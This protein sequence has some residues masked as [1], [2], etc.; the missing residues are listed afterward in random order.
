MTRILTRNLLA[1]LLLPAL[2]AGAGAKAQQCFVGQGPN[3]TVQ[4]SSTIPSTAN[5]VLVTGPTSYPSI[6]QT[7]P[8]VTLTSPNVSGNMTVPNGGLLLGAATGGF[9]GSGSLN[10]Q[11]IFINGS[12]IGSGG[13][14]IPNSAL[15]S[16]NGS[17]LGSVAI[18]TNLTLSGSY[19]TQT[20]NATG[21]GGGVTSITFSS[22]LT[23]GTITTS[24]TVG[25]G[26]IPVTNLN[27][28]T[29]ASGT[30]FWAGDGTWKTPA[31]GGS[32]SI[33]GGDASIV[34]SPS[35][36]V[37]TGTVTV[38]GPSHLT[39]FTAGTLPMGA[40]ASAF[41]ASE[42][43]DV[44]SVGVVIGAPTGGAKGAG[45]INVQTCF[46][47]NVPCA[48]SGGGG[49]T[50]PSTSDIVI[51]NGTSSPAGLA[52]VNNDLVYATAGAWAALASAN[53]SV[54]ITSAG[55]VPSLSTTL[56]SGI[57]ATSM[58]LTTPNIG[59][60]TGTSLSV[61]GQLTSTVSTGT[62][63]LVV[64]STTNVPNLN[65][66]SLGGATFAAPGP[67]GGGTPSTGAFAGLTVTS[68]LTATG[69]V[70]LAD[71]ATQATNTV[72]GNATSGTA[73][74]TALAVGSCSTAASAVIWTTNVGFGCNTSITA[75]T[76]PATGLTGT[77]NAAQ[78]PAFTGNVTSPA[79]SSVNTIPAN[80]VTNA[81]AAQMAL[82]TIKGN[83]TAG[84]ANATD[85]A[86][87]SCPD[88]SGN[89][90]NWVNGTGITCGTTSSGGG[91]ST[92]FT[93]TVTSSSGTVYTMTAAGYAAT[94]GNIVCTP[95]FTPANG[96]NPTLNIAGTGAKNIKFLTATGLV[97]PVNSEIPNTGPVCFM[98]DGTNEVLQTALVSPVPLT[99]TDTVTAPKWAGC[100]SYIISSAAQTITLPASTG[101]PTG[102]CITVQTIGVTAQLTPTSGDA[103]DNG[104]L[105]GGAAN[106][107]ITIPADLTT[108]VSYS[109]TPGVT[110]FLVP[111]GPA[112][113]FPMTWGVGQ[114]LSLDTGGI[115]FGRFATPRVVYG[116]KCKNATA[117]GGGQAMTFKY[118]TDAQTIAG[119]TTIG[120]ST[121]DMTAAA[122]TE[123]TI[124]LT[125][126]PLLVPAAYSLGGT[127]SGSSTTGS[128][129]C[130]F[131]YR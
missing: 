81:M 23:G 34:V 54:L 86:V 104:L 46:I 8:S 113:Y 43:T 28:G 60:A 82:Y 29:G 13:V 66:S 47:N 38:G 41:V 32:V 128:G 71:H 68:S 112:Q 72:I 111:L 33:T 107:S 6:S 110:A 18:G 69:L 55:G 121:F 65:A 102:G 88:T 12:P 87:P 5:G 118:A 99:G 51:S 105:G 50:W 93:G 52:P 80:T 83:P 76:M 84:T 11:S 79:G 40:G 74:P 85:M 37:G 78:L 97:S 17:L 117:A 45:S 89:H 90:L 26:N 19:P 124:N 25:V 15:L 20:L 77:M 10:A 109:G 22:P 30:T 94:A 58:A 101:L 108:I 24:G 120:A 67:I 4:T 92:V 57:A 114:D 39:T 61:T 35:P 48:T 103:V 59:A 130:Q 14:A 98:Y 21:G 62:A 115:D 73:S 44:G 125:S 123:T 9:Q 122:G 31:G 116:V 129:R 56:P 119:G 96:A 126:I 106:V 53:N 49:V 1:I 91:S 36:L 2:C 7:L 16:G 95:S 131:T 3:C 70:T 27:S 42:I 75:A 127:V 64:S 63:P 100:Q